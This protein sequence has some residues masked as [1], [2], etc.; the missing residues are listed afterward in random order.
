MLIPASTVGAHGA[1]ATYVVR[2]G[3]SLSGIA[4]K[5]SVSLAELLRLNGLQVDSVILPGRSLVV[6]SH[7]AAAPTATAAAASGAKY[8][9]RAGDSLYGVATKL[10]VR[11]AD[12]LAT[13]N[14][15]ITSVILPGQQLS[16][17]AGAAQGTAS[18][19]STVSGATYIVVSGDS[20]GR[21]ASRHGVSLRDLLTV[22]AMTAASLI[23]PGMTLRLPS[24]AS[25]P[26]TSS[27]T[28]SPSPSTGTTSTSS[29][30]AVVA[31]A[32][33][34]EGKPYKFFSA[35]PDTFDCS[36]LTKAAYAQIGI[37]LVHQSRSQA[38]Q[39]SP[40]NFLS[41]PIRAGDLV[42]L[43]ARGDDVITHVGLALSSSSWV[44]ATRPGNPVTIS[45]LPAPARI[46]AVRRLVP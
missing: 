31:F 28:P 22:N 18:G 10:G 34:Q 12:L 13:N 35:G 15:A 29:I 44:H 33:A 23:L 20:L 46:F 32:R 27:P 4:G 25:T 39:G 40:V 26:P 16:V 45:A 14:L 3:D 6:P 19:T 7:A 36:G 21:I 1:P 42:F 43:A 37:T 2:E 9:V 41:E 17:P 38:Q 8:T 5:L 30:D 11:L 24:G